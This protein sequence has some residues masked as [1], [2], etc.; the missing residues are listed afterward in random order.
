MIHQILNQTLKARK[1]IGTIVETEMT[2]RRIETEDDTI[3]EGGLARI[4][5]IVTRGQDIM[6]LTNQ[7][8]DII[9]IRL[10]D[11]LLISIDTEDPDQ[12]AFR[13]LNPNL[14]PNHILHKEQREEK[15]HRNLNETK[16]PLVSRPWKKE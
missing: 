2:R 7:S 13:N 1:L 11:T 9:E 3:V 10:L 16:N 5:D 14:D 4:R 8:T 12:G 6:D 15:N